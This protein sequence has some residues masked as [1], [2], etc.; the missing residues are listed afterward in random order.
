MLF[1]FSLPL[2]VGYLSSASA[3]SLR[4]SEDLK[5]STTS[6]LSW[7]Q[8]HGKD[9]ASEEEKMTRMEVWMANHGTSIL[10]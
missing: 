5:L 10:E 4:A 1:R 8:E 7:A 2:L 3:A 9:Y 6:F